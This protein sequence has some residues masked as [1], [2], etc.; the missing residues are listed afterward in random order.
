MRKS[1]PM[2]SA[3]AALLGACATPS[4][5]PLAP[6]QVAAPVRPPLPP[7]A[8]P[9]SR[10]PECDPTCLQAWQNEVQRLQSLLTAPTQP[11]LPASQPMR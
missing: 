2:L 6:S 9:P 3:L 7:S 11:Q 1:L 5:S 4:T 8:R 10:P